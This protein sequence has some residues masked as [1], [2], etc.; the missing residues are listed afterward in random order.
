M[1]MRKIFQNYEKNSK[2][3]IFPRKYFKKDILKL[4]K[5]MQKVECMWYFSGYFRSIWTTVYQF[6]AYLIWVPRLGKPV[7]KK[8]L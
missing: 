2:K 5:C 8:K 6:W 4:I 7:K 1:V 3:K